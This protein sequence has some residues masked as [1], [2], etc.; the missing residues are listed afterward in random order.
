MNE[1]V[2]SVHKVSCTDLKEVLP[3]HLPP[4]LVHPAPCTAH[5]PE[6]ESGHLMSA[7]PKP[8]LLDELF[9]LLEA[10]T[11][12]REFHALPTVFV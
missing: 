3:S 4:Q 1:A 9:H 2:R 6:K 5:S 7:N 12:L 8:S 11:S 10:Q